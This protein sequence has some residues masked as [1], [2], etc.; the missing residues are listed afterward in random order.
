MFEFLKKKETDNN[1]YAP[2]SGVCIDITQVKDVVFS[3]KMMGDG[4]AIIPDSCSIKA[5]ADGKIKMLFPTKHAF[6]LEMSNGQELL[7]HI[8]IDTVELNGEGF[9][10]YCKAGDKVQKG[11]KVITFDKSLLDRNDLDMTTMIIVTNSKN[12]QYEKRNV[13]KNVDEGLCVLQE[14]PNNV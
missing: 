3:K 10:S 11:D 9:N 13:G 8:G 7:V 6:G 5:P 12:Q 1:I 4:F 14:V 2:V